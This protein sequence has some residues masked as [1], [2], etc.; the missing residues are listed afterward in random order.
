MRILS[1]LCLYLALFLPPGRTPE[2]NLK[3][4]AT[5]VGV[6]LAICFPVLT[7]IV[8]DERPFLQGT[9]PGELTPS[10]TASGQGY[11]QVHSLG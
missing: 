10:Y 11:G 5:I 6:P 9:S 8:A 1:G 7:R 3:F 2:F 4:V